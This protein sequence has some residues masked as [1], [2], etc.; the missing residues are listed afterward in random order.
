MN[1]SDSQRVAR[2]MLTEEL[3]A[4]L[5][6]LQTVRAGSERPER[7]VVSCPRGAARRGRSSG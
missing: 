4:V 2:E 7:R 1:R 3:D 5:E 6:Q